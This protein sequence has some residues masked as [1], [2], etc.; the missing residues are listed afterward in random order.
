MSNVAAG[1]LRHQVVIEQQVTALTSSGEQETNWVT[2]ATV[3]AEIAP[4]SA[5][6]S[7]LSE[8]V[9]S[10]VSVRITIR[11]LDGVIASM[12]VVQGSTVYNVEGVIRDPQSGVEWMTLACST[13]LNNG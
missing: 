4:L 10:K 13:G 2:F 9:Q 11:S 1:R 3:W 5:R 8:Q 7:M 12:R 6:E